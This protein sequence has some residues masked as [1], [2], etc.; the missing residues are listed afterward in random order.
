LESEIW[1]S[2]RSGWKDSTSQI[3]DSRF[4]YLELSVFGI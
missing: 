4:Q 2:E 3:T 1:N